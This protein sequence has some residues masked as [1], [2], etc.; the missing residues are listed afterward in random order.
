MRLLLFDESS[1]IIIYDGLLIGDYSQAHQ[2]AQ[3]SDC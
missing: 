2:A 1:D 3:V